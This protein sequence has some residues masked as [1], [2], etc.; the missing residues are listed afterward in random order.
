MTHL[1]AWKDFFGWIRTSDVW[2]GMD[3]KERQNV[4]KTEKAARDGIL[5]SVRIERLLTKYAPDRYEF[6]SVVIVHEK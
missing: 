2:K 1:E 5:R 3:R 6:R 4:Y